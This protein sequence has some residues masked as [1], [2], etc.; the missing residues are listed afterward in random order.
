M[1]NSDEIYRANKVAHDINASIHN[2]AVTY[3]HHKSCRKIMWK[4]L[5]TAIESKK[6]TLL[7]SDVLEL[8]CGTGTMVEE[9]LAE[10]VAS[11]T[12]LDLSDGMLQEATHLHANDRVSFV[13]NPLATY[14]KDS[15]K[16]YHIIYSFSFLHHLPNVK[17]GLDQIN[18]LLLPNG[19]YIALH[20]TL[21]TRKM[22][23]LERIDE[24]LQCLAGDAGWCRRPIRHRLIQ[25]L[26]ALIP[27][28]RCYARKWRN[29]LLFR[30]CKQETHHED[31][32]DYQLNQPFDLAIY[33]NE[34]I[35]VCLYSFFAFTKLH[36]LGN[37]H[38]MQMLIFQKRG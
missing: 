6:R 35:E 33:A 25:V 5:S 3:L 38:N 1:I 12:G 11:Y 34:H 19:I 9:V 32:V 20:E 31:L 8:G 14:A 22:S 21:N 37:P 28:L 29:T 27:E 18:S 2:R 16:K 24:M 15:S 7:A 10:G 36:F 4:R 23:P 13:K 26:F 17:D 30:N